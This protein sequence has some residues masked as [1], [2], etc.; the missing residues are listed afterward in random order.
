M[1]SNSVK[2]NMGSTL[3]P[4]PFGSSRP[5][6]PFDQRTPSLFPPYAP[7]S[8]L[9]HPTSTL[10]NSVPHPRVLPPIIQ[11]VELYHHPHHMPSPFM[12][13]NMSPSKPPEPLSY[14]TLPI[15]QLPRDTPSTKEGK[16]FGM[17]SKFMVRIVGWWKW[18]KVVIYI[19]SEPIFVIFFVMNE[20]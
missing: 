11:P 9:G 19:L 3:V 7:S 20:P 14:Y 4:F 8:F 15:N 17:P 2:T 6:L 5:P 1:E 12:T 13:S 16:Y 18:I 10:N